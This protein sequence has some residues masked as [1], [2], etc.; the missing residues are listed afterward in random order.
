MCQFLTV[1]QILYH[2]STISLRNVMF[3]CKFLPVDQR[4][5]K[6]ETLKVFKNLF[7]IPCHVAEFRRMWFGGN[8]W[9]FCRRRAFKW[10]TCAW[11]DGM[12]WSSVRTAIAAVFCRTSFS[13]SRHLRYTA[14]SFFLS[15]AEGLICI[16]CFPCFN[17]VVVKDLLKTWEKL[18]LTSR[19]AFR[20]PSFSP[21][22]S[23]LAFVVSSG[24]GMY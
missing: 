17:K 8:Y 10:L 9:L 22:C 3:P 1:G 21:T 13:L 24:W 18:S 15:L 14:L 5:W 23:T 11:Y 16:G 2:L 12:D 6:K 4:W 19:N 20:V 7:L